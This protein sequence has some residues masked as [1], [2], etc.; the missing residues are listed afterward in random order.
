MRSA[1]AL[2]RWVQALASVP[3]AKMVQIG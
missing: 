2:K 3:V 1:R